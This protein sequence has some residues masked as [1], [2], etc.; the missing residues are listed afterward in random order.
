MRDAI[1]MVI[2][3]SLVIIS[4]SLWRIERAID[5]GMCERHYHYHNAFDVTA[6][7]GS[8]VYLPGEGE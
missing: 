7:P 2:A 5:A 6:E 1:L 4:A 3:L 8:T